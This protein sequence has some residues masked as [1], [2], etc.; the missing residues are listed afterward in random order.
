MSFINN[1]SSKSSSDIF[2]ENNPIHL[3]CN[4]REEINQP[5][6]Y[7]WTPLYRALISNNIEAMKE[8]LKEG[9]DPNI[10]NNMNETPLYQ[11]IDN[12][13]KEAILLLLD[14]EA[15]CNICKSDG[16]S[17]LHLAI[18]KLAVDYIELLLNKGANP[19]LKNKLYQQTPLHLAIKSKLNISIIKLLLEYNADFTIKDKYNCLPMD[20]CED[21][22]YKQEIQNLINMTNSKGASLSKENITEMELNNNT[23]N[24]NIINQ[25]DER[26]FFNT[27]YSSKTETDSH[28]PN[29][30][31]QNVNCTLSNEHL[32]R[33]INTIHIDALVNKQSPTQFIKRLKTTSTFNLSTPSK[34]NGYNNFNQYENN[35]AI[36]KDLIS[37]INPLD[38]VNQ[39]VTTTNNSNIFSELQNKT[40]DLP[41]AQKTDNE[42]K[43]NNQF[44]NT[45]QENDLTY[46]KSKSNILTELPFTSNKKIPFYNVNEQNNSDFVFE[47]EKEVNNNNSKKVNI[48]YKAGI[49]RVNQ[50]TQKKTS[51][52]HNKYND[53]KENDI[54]ITNIP[55]NTNNYLY[56][57]ENDHFN[58]NN[59]NVKDLAVNKTEINST[60]GGGE[61]L[62]NSNFVSGCNISNSSNK[63]KDKEAQTFLN[64]RNTSNNSMRPGSIH[65]SNYCKSGSNYNSTRNS[66]DNNKNIIT[67][68]NLN[69]YTLGVASTSSNV[70]PKVSAHF[71]CKK[72]SI[73]SNCSYKGVPKLYYEGN[74]P[75]SNHNTIDFNN[76]MSTNHNIQI[77][78]SSYNA[79]RLHEWLLSCDLLHYYNILIEQGIYNIDKCINGIQSGDLQLTYKDI[80]DIGIKKPGHIFR[81]LIKLNC[82]AGIIDNRIVRYIFPL[83][84]ENNNDIHI[85]VSQTFCGCNM[86]KKKAIKEYDVES[87]LKSK[88]LGYLKDNFIHNGFD[89]FEFIII[90]LF[91]S[92]MVDDNFLLERMH[93]YN[94]S[95][96]YK[97]KKALNDERKM[98]CKQL[99][100]KY[101]DIEQEEENR[102]KIEQ[103]EVCVLF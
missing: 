51:F 53:N 68:G 25:S 87:W 70:S 69:T 37:E 64:N 8:L 43:M 33:K 11:A 41:S 35:S 32:I 24:D 93:I 26:N 95:D 34:T 52:Y 45:L 38:L 90:Q 55:V 20:Y 42:M 67:V 12:D 78:F 65:N 48:D 46:S 79:K 50:S 75:S 62:Y 97:V 81:F 56:I 57:E 72:S 83:K 40:Q 66:N 71:K 10:A 27:K 58:S 19:N 60:Y 31:I 21:S 77:N 103:C 99:G 29:P 80:E 100:K 15:N 9:A 39:L 16:N 18:K 96:R 47:K 14:N 3:F 2:L 54:N 28:K 102:E 6:E 92:F 4:T 63:E 85:G 86:R 74:S 13:N 88:G 101:V 30:L 73:L 44:D 89:I 98:I 36:D 84:N 59:H 76:T 1:S 7:G 91:S 49:A 5:N 22:V 17:P 82:D 61:I 23:P 94:A